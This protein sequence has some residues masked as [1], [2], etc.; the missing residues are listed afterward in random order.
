MRR[1]VWKPFWAHFASARTHHGLSEEDFNKEEQKSILA[2]NEGNNP[3]RKRKTNRGP[4][5]S[6]AEESET[7]QELN[8]DGD[9]ESD[10]LEAGPPKKLTKTK[11][12]LS[13]LAEEIRTD[14]DRVTRLEKPKK[15][16]I[17]EISEDQDDLDEFNLSLVATSKTLYKS[18]VRRFRRDYE[19]DDENLDRG[20]SS[21]AAL[22]LPTKLRRSSRKNVGHEG[23]TKEAQSIPLPEKP[24][25][26]AHLIF[27]Q[28][29]RM[30]NNPV[31]VKLATAKPRRTSDSSLDV[32]DSDHSNSD[33][34]S[35]D[36]D[37][38][39]DSQSGIEPE[40]RRKNTDA[41]DDSDTPSIKRRR[42]IA[43]RIEMLAADSV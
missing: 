13:V 42:Y 41:D 6:Q 43:S 7:E 12:K 20:I 36:E 23:H 14:T 26:P 35:S 39:N 40:K 38:D 18:K 21:T 8:D 9:N 24:S 31:K 5:V 15:H 1:N 34:A 37:N 3:E 17:G 30:A 22:N 11:K 2:C 27:Q 28:E 33:D 25:Q 32:S 4:V 29:L 16:K 19:D 10:K